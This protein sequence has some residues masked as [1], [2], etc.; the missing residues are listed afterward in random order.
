MRLLDLI[1]QS[2]EPFVVVPHAHGAPMRVS[3]PGDFAQR[4]AECPL[5]FVIADDLTRASAELAFADGDRLAGCL[6]LLR[7]PAPLIWLEWSDAIHQQVICQCGTVAERDPDAVG[8]HVGVLL[9][10]SLCGRT[11]MA[12]TFW[13]FSSAAGECGAQMSPLETHIDLDDKFEPAADGN[14]ML[15]GEFASL[16]ACNSGV[17][18]LLERIRFRF[19]ERWLKYYQQAARDAG[20]RADLV[21][22]SLAAVAHDIPL[23]LAFFLLLNAKGATRPVPVQ[24]STLNRKRLAQDRA[25]LLDHIEVHASLPGHSSNEQ[26]PAAADFGSRRTPRLHHVRG[27]LVRRDERVFWRTPHL[28]GSAHQGVVRSRTVCLSFSRAGSAEAAASPRFY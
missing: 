26:D 20:S 9:Q 5:R 17:G 28:R 24:R 25:P 16:R 23:L 6:D 3:G 13:S 1:A 21:R 19:D 22:K 7:I 10:A 8:R 18:D 4:I 27:H 14:S 15:R 11:G 12:R 2:R